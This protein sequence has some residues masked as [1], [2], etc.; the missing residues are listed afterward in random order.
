M[1]NDGWSVKPDYQE[2][3]LQYGHTHNDGS[4]EEKLIANLEAQV[5][6]VR[7]LLSMWRER[8]PMKEAP[9]AQQCWNCF[10]VCR[11]LR[12]ALDGEEKPCRAKP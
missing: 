5:S 1:T 10:E 9:L 6:R 3:V 11:Q 8:C 2:G 12:E 7:E 4:A